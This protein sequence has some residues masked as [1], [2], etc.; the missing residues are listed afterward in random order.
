MSGIIEGPEGFYLVRCGKRIEGRNISFEQ[1][2]KVLRSRFERIQFDQLIRR[3]KIELRRKANVRG[4]PTGLLAK[5]LER[6]DSLVA[7]RS[8]EG[9]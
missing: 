2:Q 3:K 5:V 1:A 7:V 8:G 4:N 9:R 6:L